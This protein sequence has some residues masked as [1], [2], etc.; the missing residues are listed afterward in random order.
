MEEVASSR[1]MHPSV[2]ENMQNIS[3]YR[4]SETSISLTD[5]LKKDSQTERLMRLVKSRCEQE[6]AQSA[7]P[8]PQ[9]E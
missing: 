3:A 8:E 4:A 6:V 7:S 9:F 2:L 5:E 1:L